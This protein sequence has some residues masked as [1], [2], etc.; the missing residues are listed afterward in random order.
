MSLAFAVV[1]RADVPTVECPQ[2]AVHSTNLVR[3]SVGRQ[4]GWAKLTI[5]IATDD[6]PRVNIC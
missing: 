2:R 4:G 6:S 5:G 3:S 1:L